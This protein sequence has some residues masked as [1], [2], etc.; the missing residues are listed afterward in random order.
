MVRSIHLQCLLR[1]A[2]SLAIVHD[3]YPPIC[4]KT[5]YILASQF[6]LAVRQSH[7]GNSLKLFHRSS[8]ITHLHLDRPHPAFSGGLEILTNVI[9]EHHISRT[10]LSVPPHLRPPLI[11]QTHSQLVDFR[12]G[13]PQPDMG[14][15]DKHVKGGAHVLL[16]VG[17]R[18]VE[19]VAVGEDA[20]VAEC[21]DEEAS[22]G[23]E[24][25][26][27]GQHVQVRLPRDAHHL[28]EEP[29][30]IDIGQWGRRIR[31]RCAQ[32]ADDGPGCGR[33]GNRG[34]RAARGA[35]AVVAPQVRT[36]QVG[37]EGA[38]EGGIVPNLAAFEAVPGAVGGAAGD[39]EVDPA[40]G[41]VVGDFVV[42]D[43]AEGG[44]NA[45]AANIEEADSWRP[46][47]RSSH[48]SW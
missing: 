33:G 29:L 26:H 48:L 16:R 8:C 43:S 17:R 25:T 24:R 2:I 36:A 37:V 4:L 7:A 42:E 39:G 31:A 27:R 34:I 9:Q 35:G 46:E 45:D 41:N 21:A 44:D 12:I 15:T 13:L 3:I 19:R 30:A 5:R 11:Q 23:L 1:Y 6:R 47:F 28:P 20:R 14:A 18:V 10:Q 32:H 38:E 40:G 22:A